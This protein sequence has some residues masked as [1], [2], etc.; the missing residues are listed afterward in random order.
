[1]SARATARADS[2]RRAPA[3]SGRRA[4][5]TT[6]PRAPDGAPQQPVHRCARRLPRHRPRFDEAGR[7]E[8]GDR[9]ARDRRV[10]PIRWARARR[11][12]AAS[13]HP[14]ERTRCPARSTRC[15]GAS[16]SRA[17]APSAGPARRSRAGRSR[18]RCGT[19]RARRSPET[20]RTNARP[21]TTPARTPRSG[22]T[23][24]GCPSTSS[25]PSRT[26]AR[27]VPSGENRGL[28]AALAL[29]DHRWFAARVAAHDPRLVPR[30]VREVPLVPHERAPVGRPTGIPRVVG[31][32]DTIG[33]RGPVERHDGDVARVV[34]LDRARDLTVDRDRRARTRGRRGSSACRSTPSTPTTTRRP[35]AAATTNASSS[36]QHHPP[37]IA[38]RRP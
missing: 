18:L 19:T 9:A 25:A 12:T 34:A 16:P 6:I 8:P 21:T 5:A 11:W 26:H 35:S 1:M 20:T 27:R 38:A 15:R 23:S 17:R 24:T 3:R 32:R 22:S 10:A 33:P 2:S 30:H 28:A 14:T 13:P 36:A 31:V 29:D 37:P 4:G 7:F